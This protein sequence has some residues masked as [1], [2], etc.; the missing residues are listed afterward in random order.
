MN[1]EGGVLKLGHH[2]VE[3]NDS[4]L[5]G[6]AKIIDLSPEYGALAMLP[7]DLSLDPTIDDLDQVHQRGVATEGVETELFLFFFILILIFIRDFLVFILL[8]E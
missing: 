1:T 7:V 5:D 8:S 2:D 6:S 3:E 4:G